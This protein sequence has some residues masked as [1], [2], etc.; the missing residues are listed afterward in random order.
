MHIF[1]EFQV[2]THIVFTL[3]GVFMAGKKWRF[4]PKSA[5][6]FPVRYF[7]HHNKTRDYVRTIRLKALSIC[8]D[9]SD[10]Q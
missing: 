10:G 8:P 5:I 9:K 7:P 1:L 3:L 2:H 6:F 4:W